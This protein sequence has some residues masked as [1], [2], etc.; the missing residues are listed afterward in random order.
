MRKIRSADQS[1]ARYESVV[2]AIH[3]DFAQ[4]ATV[5][6]NELIEGKSGIFRQIDVAIRA[7]IAGYKCLVIVEC[8]DYSRPVEIGKVDELIGKMD[9]V[10]AVKA[11][12]VSDSGFTEGALKR[13][14][15]EPRIELVSVFDAQN[16]SLKTS[17]TIPVVLTYYFVETYSFDISAKTTL[18]DTM[19]LYRHAE[20][21][22]P[23]VWNAYISS[24]KKQE[25][26]QVGELNIE[27][28]YPFSGFTDVKVTYHFLV[29]KKRY[30]NH[31]TIGVGKGIVNHANKSGVL[32]PGEFRLSITFHFDRL[33]ELYERV[34]DD[35]VYQFEVE[36][37]AEL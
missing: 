23:A 29:S 25:P 21:R 18:G 36:A 19:A 28:N 34:L 6:E 30:R 2:A 15:R 37:V 35:K 11:V 27:E 24:D 32:T 33:D 31:Y 17:A 26:L 14:Q 8:K 9:D 20:E 22:A 4:D 13:A 3:R 5:T 1:G 10:G 7:D 16:G 12:L